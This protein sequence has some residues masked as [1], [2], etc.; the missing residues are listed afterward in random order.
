MFSVTPLLSIEKPAVARFR[1]LIENIARTATNCII[2]KPAPAAK[3]R[4]FPDLP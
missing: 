1:Y 2:S 3:K 4:L